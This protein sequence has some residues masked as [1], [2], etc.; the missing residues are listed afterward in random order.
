MSDDSKLSPYLFA[1]E[2]DGIETARFQKCEGLEAET[3][4]IE[5]EEG[6]GEVHH[7]HGRTRYPN[8]ILEKGISDNDELFN[9]Y[10]NT[11]LEDRKLERKT[12]SIVLK[13]NQDEEIKRWNFFKAFPCR[14]IGPK[15]DY[16]NKDTFA[17]ERIEIAHEGLEVDNDSYPFDF[18]YVASVELKVDKSK[19]IVQ[20][21]IP[22][23]P[24][25]YIDNSIPKIF[26]QDADY[27]RELKDEE[28]VNKVYEAA[29]AHSSD[30]YIVGTKENN[31]EE[32]RCDNF[33]ETVIREAGYNPLDYMAGSAKSKKI[34]DHIKNALENDLTE[35]INKNDSPC[36]YG[37]AYV[38]YMDEG[39]WDGKPVDSHGGLILFK[40]ERV[41]YIDNS[42]HNHRI[43]NTQNYLGGVE[44]H[45]YNSIE[46]FQADY[47]QTYKN[48]YYLKINK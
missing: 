7:F 26:S 31:W 25:N 13:N 28:T 5:F 46:A 21:G 4:I 1:V 47:G 3:E 27:L 37:G 34:N 6:G 41:L 2:I 9:W 30:K 19:W 44:T 17:V 36:I 11:L 24:K 42:S 8:I 14:W 38:V 12:G 10:K 45:T 22:D 16:K 15:L 18:P 40:D 39:D 29:S 32:F 33:N 35:K 43:G 23:A 20:N 48:F